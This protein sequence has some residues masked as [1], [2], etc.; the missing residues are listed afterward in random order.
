MRSGVR[1]VDLFAWPHAPLRLSVKQAI[2]GFVEYIVG[3]EIGQLT[4]STRED[5]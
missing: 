4:S 3:N 1:A 2:M 5:Q